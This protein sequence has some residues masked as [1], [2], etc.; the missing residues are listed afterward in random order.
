MIDTILNI[1]GKT[2]LHKLFRAIPIHFVVSVVFATFLT[3]YLEEPVR[4]RLKLW[5]E[6]KKHQSPSQV[7]IMKM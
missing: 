1:N 7:I 6:N 4:K 3:I 5:K 2:H